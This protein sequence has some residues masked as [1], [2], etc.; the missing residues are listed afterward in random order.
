MINLNFNPFPELKTEH[1]VLRPFTNEDAQDF[2]VLRSDKE[3]M[4]FICRPIAQTV[5][6]ALALI[7]QMNEG[8]AGQQN[9][10]WA[11]CLKKDPKVIGSIGFVRINKEHY[12]A[13]V[14]YL[15]STKFQGRGFMKE[16]LTAVVDYGF[17][18]I[19]LHSIEAIL[20]PNNKACV[21]LLE[22][23]KFRKE[24]HFKEDFFYNGKFLDS[25]V[26]SRLSP[27]K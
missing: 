17:K 15:L 9:I 27:I 21:N 24:A 8:I 13:E 4:K 20:D 23:N 16:A 12:R 6:D 14:G 18:N 2:F 3:I 7:E 11:I 5:A 19:K 22:K 1:L 26:Y 25:L 10:S